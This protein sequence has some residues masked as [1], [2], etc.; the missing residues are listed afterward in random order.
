VKRLLGELHLVEG[1]TDGAISYLESCVTLSRELEDRHGEGLAL[2]LKAVVEHDAGH[3]EQ[4]RLQYEA[5]IGLLQEHGFRRLQGVFTGY[6]GVLF[7]QNGQ[8]EEA[9][10]NLVRACALLAR[11]D[12]DEHLGVVFAHRS[13]VEAELGRVEEARVAARAASER[14]VDDPLRHVVTL[15]A[16]IL[17][18]ERPLSVAKS[19]MEA[20]RRS[21]EVRLAL[22]CLEA[23]LER[24]S[25][26]SNEQRDP[27]ILV[28]EA[29]GRWFQ[30]P[31]AEPVDLER[32]R[33][34]RLI[35]TCLLGQRMN[36]PGVP[37][38]WDGLLEA[39]WPG[40]R[41]IPSA[42]A[43]R[44]RVAV[45][46]LRK[47]GLRSVLRTVDEGYLFD[48]AIETRLSDSPLETR[49]PK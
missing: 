27:T 21:V 22:R 35:V 11:G 32:R 42:G 26:G 45:S 10:S 19:A 6:L 15:Q 46:T 12:D 38:P 47:L 49:S 18:R 37:I 25:K 16:A 8:L 5:V 39:G 30:P 2:G 7:Q 3:L 34:L 29:T 41:V 31:H 44:V 36:K 23:A 17:D 24:Q 13:G 43:H 1:R 40:E 33:P 9:E 20:S 48:P 4:A 14:L 28:V